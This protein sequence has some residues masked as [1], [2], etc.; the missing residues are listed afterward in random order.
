MEYF[1]NTLICKNKKKKE[2]R[3]FFSKE[4]KDMHVPKLQKGQFS[5]VQLC[6]S[7]VKA[8]RSGVLITFLFLLT[9]TVL[10]LYVFNVFY[11]FILF[12][13]L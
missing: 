11:N 5:R 2:E 12:Y 6:G 1:H 3:K 10:F 7:Q 8:Y 9:S 13:L 4:K